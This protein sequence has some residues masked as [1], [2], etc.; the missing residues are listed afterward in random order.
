MERKPH[1][2]HLMFDK[3]TIKAPVVIVAAGALFK[4]DAVLM[5]QRPMHKAHGGEWEFPGGKIEASETPQHA[6]QRELLEE[7]GIDASPDTMEPAGFISHAY[8]DVHVVMLLFV[9][10]D[11]KNDITLHEHEAVQWVKREDLYA[12]AALPADKPLLEKLLWYL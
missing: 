10:R 2:K 4:D 5:C 1:N 11:W 7:L 3:T 12:F 9:I 8:P 6:L